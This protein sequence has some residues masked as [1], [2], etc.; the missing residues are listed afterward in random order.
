MGGEGAG[1]PDTAAKTITKRKENTNKNL[2][3]TN[4]PYNPDVI[5]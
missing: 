3:K 2:H 5:R 4:T 1:N